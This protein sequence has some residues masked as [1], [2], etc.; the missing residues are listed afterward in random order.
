MKKL[1]L[2]LAILISLTTSAE[3]YI[4][5]IAYALW[6]RRE[7]G[8]TIYGATVIK[9]PKQYQGNVTIPSHVTY[10]GLTY[11]VTMIY[12]QAFYSCMG[13]T[14]VTLPN[15]IE[16]IAQ[17]AFWN[18][19]NL[20][21]INIPPSVKKIARIAFSGCEKLAKV[22][23]TDVKA[24]CNIEFETEESNPLLFSHFL[25]LNG[26]KIKNLVIPDGVE[27]IKG[28]A[29]NECYGLISVTIPNSVTSIE[30]RAFCKCINLESVKIGNG[31]KRIGNFAFFKNENLS[32]VYLYAKDCPLFGHYCFSDTN[33]QKPFYYIMPD[34]EKEKLTWALG[35]RNYIKMK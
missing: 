28:N 10:E 29:F 22:N 25:F 7:Y 17:G 6:S 4:D 20:T 23:I 31:V 33:P 34:S 5:D 3:V 11:C 27:I 24:W 21:S 8:K 35:Y 26:K 30:E 12:T 15:T 13:I 32:V 14:S 9:C 19:S 16:Y 1:F 18:C 2:F